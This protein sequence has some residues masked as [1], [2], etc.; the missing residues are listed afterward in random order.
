MIYNIIQLSYLFFWHNNL[1]DFIGLELEGQTS[2]V[3]AKVIL[4]DVATNQILY[5]LNIQKLV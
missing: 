5:M 1:S 3:K 4:V 2:L